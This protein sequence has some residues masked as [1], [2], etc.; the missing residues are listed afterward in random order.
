MNPFQKLKQLAAEAA[1]REQ[2]RSS[3]PEIDNASLLDA[4]LDNHEKPK[5]TLAPS[6]PPAK[7]FSWVDAYQRDMSRAFLQE[8]ERE[9]ARE[10]DRYSAAAA[11]RFAE[12]MR[13]D[14]RASVF[15][16]IKP[17]TPEPPVP[18]ELKL[19]TVVK[20]PYDFE[21][22]NG[23]EPVFA[24]EVRPVGAKPEPETRRGRW[25]LCRA[26]GEKSCRYSRYVYD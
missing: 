19:A 24:E 17:A 8:R 11:A 25:V 15:D 9:R 22:V 18:V 1:A 21:I 3:K 16:D 4:M 13:A 6:A 12:A 5:P 23:A 14:Y 7:P 26:C 10:R 20:P 2:A